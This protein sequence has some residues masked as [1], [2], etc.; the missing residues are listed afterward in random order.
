VEAPPSPNGADVSSSDG[1][2][3]N[4]GEDVE[5]HTNGIASQN[6]TRFLITFLF[7]K[8]REKKKTQK[9]KSGGQG[10]NGEQERTLE[11]AAEVVH[12]NLGAARGEQEGVGAAESATSAGDDSDAIYKKQGAFNQR[13]CFPLRSSR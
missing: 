13:L 6:I 4:E 5:Q 10:S 2:H 7:R 12:D 11:A 8:A 1:R 3:G 9:L